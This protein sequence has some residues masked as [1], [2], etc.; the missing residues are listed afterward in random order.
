VVDFR[1]WPTRTSPFNEEA[2]VSRTLTIELPDELYQAFEQAAARSG[3]TPEAV[4]LEWLARHAAAPTPSGAGGAG[5]PLGGKLRRYAGIVNSG[6]PHSA[7]N[8]RIDADL[9]REYGS[10]HDVPEEEPGEHG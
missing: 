2:S 6:D 1:E 7:E 3:R 10:A 9:A 8:D 5:Y 4:A